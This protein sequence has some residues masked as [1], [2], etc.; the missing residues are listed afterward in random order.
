MKTKTITLPLPP[1]ALSPNARSHWA[2]KHKAAKSYRQAALL[3]ATTHCDLYRGVEFESYTLHFF[4]GDKRRRD[5][6]NYTARMKSALDGIS[7]AIGQD[8]SE[9][10]FDGVRFEIDKSNPRV[11][12]RAVLK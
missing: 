2:V 7:D 4:F 10:N 8:D 12:V 5:K 3:M 9:W 11:E 1:M 6:D